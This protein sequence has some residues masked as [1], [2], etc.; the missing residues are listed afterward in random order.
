MT[1]INAQAAAREAARESGGQFGAQGRTAPA[2]DAA[3][4]RDLSRARR[5]VSRHHQ[6]LTDTLDKLAALET[7]YEI[8]DAIDG[9][10]LPPEAK[11]ID[12]I[13][14]DEEPNEDGGYDIG[15]EYVRDADDEVLDVDGVDNNIWS[16][17]RGGAVW[18]SD[19]VDDQDRLDI[20]K[21]RS[22]AATADLT[23]A[24]S[25]QIVRD[26]FAATLNVKD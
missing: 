18:S 26:G 24:D 20:D 19:W 14:W 4:G 2:A 5:A 13:R 7:Q 22:W 3:P 25:E 9:L 11:F 16:T 23:G 15:F 6:A 12:L 10:D 21:V 8:A 17:G 1:D